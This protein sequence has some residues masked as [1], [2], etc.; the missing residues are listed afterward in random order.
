MS[1]TRPE[2]A[3]ESAIRVAVK[4][5]RDRRESVHFQRCRSQEPALRLRQTRARA[6]C[7]CQSR[8]GQEAAQIPGQPGASAQQARWRVNRTAAVPTFTAARSQG[9]APP[10]PCEARFDCA[11]QRLAAQLDL[12]DD[13]VAANQKTSR[14]VGRPSRPWL[15]LPRCLPGSRAR[16]LGGSAETIAPSPAP[17]LNP[18]S[19]RSY[20]G[21]ASRG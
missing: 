19:F 11:R 7:S 8:R 15:Q 4:E 1:S 9:L 10:G 13:S 6:A 20:P 16:R 21:R 2:P 12:S 18:A 3:A 14:N 17:L 5:F